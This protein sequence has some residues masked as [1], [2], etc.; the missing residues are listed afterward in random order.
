MSPVLAA[1]AGVVVAGVPAF[2]AGVFARS[3][4]RA[5]ATDVITQAAERVVHQLMA[6]LDQATETAARLDSEVK[7]LREEI[8]RL[9]HVVR[10]M[11]GDPHLL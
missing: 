6:A 9:R 3:K 2:L 10:Q 7:E 4:T 1:I 11:G 8:A 5:E